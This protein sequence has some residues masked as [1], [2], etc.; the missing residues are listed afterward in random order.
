MLNKV[1]EIINTH[2]CGVLLDHEG[3]D[4]ASNMLHL[5]V[6][7]ALALFFAVVLVACILLSWKLEIHSRPF[8][9]QAKR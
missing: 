1:K 4:N 2:D 5:V 6:L 7:P 9:M 3:D 8:S